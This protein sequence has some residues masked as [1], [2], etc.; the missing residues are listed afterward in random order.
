[1]RA[2]SYLVPVG[3]EGSNPITRTFQFTTSDSSPIIREVL[4]SST[5]DILLTPGSGDPFVLSEWTGAD[6]NVLNVVY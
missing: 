5:G 2:G 3:E 1:M 6:I 4:V